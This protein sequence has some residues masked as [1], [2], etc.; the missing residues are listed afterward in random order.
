MEKVSQICF[1]PTN[2]TNYDT[3]HHINL[4]LSYVNC[5]R[6]WY[7]KQMTSEPNHD[8]HLNRQ[9]KTPS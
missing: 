6:Y 8:E 9:S 3:K 7:S 4:Y 5:G 2:I 1:V